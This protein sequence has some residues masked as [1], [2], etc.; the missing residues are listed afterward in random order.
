MNNSPRIASDASAKNFIAIVQRLYC[1]SPNFNSRPTAFRRKK[2][3]PS[4]AG[5]LEREFDATRLARSGE[6]EGLLEIPSF[7][8]AP[9]YVAEQD[10]E[11]EILRPVQLPISSWQK[12]SKS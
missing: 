7:A 2:L 1:I 4:P 10:R 9:D 3:G 11:R 8:V 12:P 5:C 6:T